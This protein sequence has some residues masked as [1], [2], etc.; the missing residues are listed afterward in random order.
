M[1]SPNCQSLKVGVYRNYAY[2]GE[3]RIIVYSKHGESYDE[4]QDAVSICRGPCDD[5]KHNE[6]LKVAEVAGGDVWI[7]GKIDKHT[8]IL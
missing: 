1:F 8:S 2:V 3:E 7:G 4:I 6:K 5:C